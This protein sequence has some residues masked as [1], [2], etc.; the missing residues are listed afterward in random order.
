MIFC[1]DDVLIPAQLIEEDAQGESQPVSVEGS[2]WLWSAFE[3]Q[4]GAL[5]SGVLFDHRSLWELMVS[6]LWS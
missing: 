6:V 1:L 5:Y 2:L 4:R 3:K